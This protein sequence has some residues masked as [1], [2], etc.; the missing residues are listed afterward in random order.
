M[1]SALTG[2]ALGVLILALTMFSIGLGIKT[3]VD[4]NEDTQCLSGYIAENA[5]VTKL[6]AQATIKREAAVDALLDRTTALSV[7]ARPRDPAKAR[8]ELRQ[9]FSDY[10]KARTEVAHERAANPLAEL[11]QSC[12]DVNP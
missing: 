1:A 11:P 9:V 2:R 10:R 5:R 3:A 12:N 6:R 4:R 8:A 7:S